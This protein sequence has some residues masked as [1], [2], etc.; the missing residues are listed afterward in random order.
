M[1]SLEKGVTWKHLLQ[2]IGS[3][4]L[5]CSSLM[6]REDE[7]SETSIFYSLFVCISKYEASKYQ[8]KRMNSSI[9]TIKH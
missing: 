1:E 6:V 5:I 9:R 3:T 2:P 7:R 4:M 8:V